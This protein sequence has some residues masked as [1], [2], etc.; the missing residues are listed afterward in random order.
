MRVK[1]QRLKAVLSV[2]LC[3][4]LLLSQSMMAVGA[5]ELP[6]PAADP[7][8]TAAGQ[9]ATDGGAADEWGADRKSVV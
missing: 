9:E 5:S 8:E 4:A 7:T 2:M 3:I 6:A 1:R